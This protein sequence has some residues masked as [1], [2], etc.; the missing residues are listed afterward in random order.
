MKKNSCTP[1]NRKKYSCNGLKKIHTR[2]LITK[3]NSCGPKIPLPPPFPLH[4]LSNGPSQEP[5]FDGLLS[6]P[7]TDTFC[8]LSKMASASSPTATGGGKNSD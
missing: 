3:K 8:G 6:A 5:I 1:I 7:H 4:N 2:N